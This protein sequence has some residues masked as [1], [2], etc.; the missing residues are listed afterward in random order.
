MSQV[1]YL[2]NTTPDD[3]FSDN[4]KLFQHT[5]NNE[6][7][8]AFRNLSELLA[9]ISVTGASELDIDHPYVVIIN[10]KT[11]SLTT[12]K[13]EIPP[14]ASL[15]D[16][17]TLDFEDISL[18]LTTHYKHL[19]VLAYS[20]AEFSITK[21]NTDIK[22]YHETLKNRIIRMKTWCGLNNSKVKKCPCLHTMTNCLNIILQNDF[23]SSTKLRHFVTLIN[24]EIDFM[25]L[26]TLPQS[27]E[28]YLYCIGNWGFIAH[29]LTCDELTFCALSIFKN[30]FSILEPT[31]PLILDDNS[32]LSFLFSLRDSY[33]GGNAFHNFRHAV[34][35]LQATFYFLLRI[36]TLPRFKEFTESMHLHPNDQIRQTNHHFKAHI[37][38]FSKDDS[39]LDPIQSLALL[40][41]SVGHDV[42]HPGLTND[43]M[44]KNKT[45]ISKVYSTNSTLENYHSTIF[46]DI[47]SNHWPAFLDNQ[48]TT[49]K[50]LPLNTNVLQVESIIA[51]DMANHFEYI[52]KINDIGKVLA[53]P[54]Q[55]RSIKTNLKHTS[56]LLSLIIKCAD[57]SNVARPLTVSARWGVVLTREF[58]EIQQLNENLHGKLD[59]NALNDNREFPKFSKDI[60]DAFAE[61][62]KLFNGQLFFIT[63]F[64]DSLFKECAN[65]LPELKFSADILESN[66]KFWVDRRDNFMS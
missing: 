1:L 25:S 35:V 40:V 51:T 42:G 17:N 4:I 55:R 15:S 6:Q 46:Q 61:F 53:D 56:T 26:L 30:C 47:L 23:P 18:L 41:A 28:Y 12:R 19:N 62:P 37:P 57:I 21:V 54:V 39:I 60:E 24:N 49:D 34:D 50:K 33:R 5:L 48:Y 22:N 31:S 13:S 52:G 58:D 11:L 7:V 36:Q 27:K 3:L 59:L 45:P 38:N 16:L 65:A 2:D 29:E 20:L 32:I 44:N 43:F 9:Y 64:A 8:S 14:G 10:E 66:R 63:T